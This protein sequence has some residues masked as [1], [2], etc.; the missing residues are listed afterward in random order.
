MYK[1]A[2]RLAQMG[3]KQDL[4]EVAAGVDLAEIEAAR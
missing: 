4:T 1:D 2:E 3:Q